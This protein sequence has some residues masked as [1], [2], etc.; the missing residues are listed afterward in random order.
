MLQFVLS[1]IKVFKCTVSI[2]LRLCC[3][4]CEDR[5]HGFYDILSTLAIFVAYHLRLILSWHNKIKVYIT[6]Q[7]HKDCYFSFLHYSLL[8]CIFSAFILSIWACYT[9]LICSS[10]SSITIAIFFVSILFFCPKAA[11]FN[12]ISLSL[13]WL[14]FSSLSGPNFWTNGGGQFESSIPFNLICFFLCFSSLFRDSVP[15]QHVLQLCWGKLLNFIVHFKYNVL[16][17]QAIFYLGFWEF[18]SQLTKGQASFHA[19]ILSLGLTVPCF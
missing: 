8:S 13:S 16:L 14:S 7:H 5:Y 15:K 4:F 17:Q 2:V 3:I 12:L 11:L 19:S 18:H 10:A 9:A 1:E 6:L